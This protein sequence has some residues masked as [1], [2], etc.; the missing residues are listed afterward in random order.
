V[1]QAISP[2]HEQAGVLDHGGDGEVERYDHDEQQR[3]GHHRHGE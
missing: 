3:D 1:S 2:V